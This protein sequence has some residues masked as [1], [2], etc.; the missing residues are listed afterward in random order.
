MKENLLVKQ[1]ISNLPDF[2]KWSYYLE[3]SNKPENPSVL[4]I[5]ENLAFPNLGSG[6]VVPIVP[7]GKSVRISCYRVVLNED[8]KIYGIKIIGCVSNPNIIR[9]RTVKVIPSWNAFT[10][11]SI[12]LACLYQ[13]TVANA[14][15]NHKILNIGTSDIKRIHQKLFK[16]MMHNHKIGAPPVDYPLIISNGI[17]ALHQRIKDF[18]TDDVNSTISDMRGKFKYLSNRGIDEES[19]LTAFREGLCSDILDS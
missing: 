11:S 3:R 19:I 9:T 2:K 4:V 1:L 12:I 16:C 14:T 15:L 18:E 10:V 13:E 5:H 6:S 7:I 8:R 17:S